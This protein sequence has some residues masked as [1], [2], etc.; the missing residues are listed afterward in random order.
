MKFKYGDGIVGIFLELLNIVTTYAV[1]L[2]TSVAVIYFFYTVAS[3]IWAMR[4]GKPT[5][6]LK[7]KIFPIIILLFVMFS[8]YALIGLV[9]DVFNLTG[10]QNG[11][12]S[13]N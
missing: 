5:G 3:Y 8:V 10:P 4:N 9:G 13:I 11:A 12:I 2:I 1:W 7:A 6:D